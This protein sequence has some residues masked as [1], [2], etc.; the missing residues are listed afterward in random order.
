[1]NSIDVI[2]YIL[3]FI[4]GTGTGFALN[5]YISKSNINKTSQKHIKA[6][7]DVVGRD[8]RGK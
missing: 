7:G 1:M 5:N 8:K 3:T 2:T 4:V 6:G